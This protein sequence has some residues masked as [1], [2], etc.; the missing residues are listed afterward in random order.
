MTW[1]QDEQFIICRYTFPLGTILSVVEF[2]ENYILQTQ[3]E[4]QSQYY[5]SE[6]VSI[7]V[8]T[9]YRHGLDRNEEKRAIL[10]ENHFY[11]SDGRT[12]DIHYVEHF[13]KLFYDHVI[14]MDIP[15]YC[16]FI[17]LDGCAG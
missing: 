2:A 11:I 8:H 1:W 3:N 4:T 6:H 12:H 17:S 15:F 16:H 13:F 14:A 10:K 9:T 7:M 5:H